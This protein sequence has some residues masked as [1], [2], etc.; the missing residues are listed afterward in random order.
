MKKL[1]LIY[2]TIFI[3]WALIL[4]SY[5]VNNDH[6]N[7][8]VEAFFLITLGSG[9]IIMVAL[10]LCYWLFYPTSKTYTVFKGFHFSGIRFK[11]FLRKKVMEAEVTFH[12][13]CKY[14][15]KG[16]NQ[17]N[18]QVN[19]LFGFGALVHKKNSHRIG[20]RY[21]KETD[22]IKLYTYNY[23]NGERFINE[24]DSCK[25]E[26]KKRI[27]LESPDYY[28]LGFYKFLYFG[29]K[30]KAPHKIRITINFK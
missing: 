6:L 30:A 27:K 7:L 5:F 8:T 22:L 11:P 9:F 29:G 15:E 25:I 23:V 21:D 12:S 20:W 18:E 3:G 1:N 10:P 2:L 13:H 28:W 24:F 14:Y 26:Q 4:I 17:L 16:N 19:K